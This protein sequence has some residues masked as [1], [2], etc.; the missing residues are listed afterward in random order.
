MEDDPTTSVNRISGKLHYLDFLSI[1]QVT[2]T[3]LLRIK[4]PKFVFPARVQFCE[5]VLR[6]HIDDPLFLFISNEVTFTR[7]GRF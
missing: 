2:V 1:S 5:F 4:C 6:Q 7:R 3:S